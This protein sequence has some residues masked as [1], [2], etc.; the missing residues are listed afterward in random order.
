MAQYIPINPAV[1]SDLLK[2]YKTALQNDNLTIN[3]SNQTRSLDN[4]I[5]YTIDD[6]YKKVMIE[7]MVAPYNDIKKGEGVSLTGS[8]IRSGWEDNSGDINNNQV[9]SA[10]CDNY[11]MFSSFMANDKCIIYVATQNLELGYIINYKIN[12]DYTLTSSGSDALHT[13]HNTI[14]LDSIK[15]SNYRILCIF[16]S[17]GDNKIYYS[18]FEINETTLVMSRIK[19]G[20]FLDIVCGQDPTLAIEKITETFFIVCVRP[21]INI[22]NNKIFT[23]N[24]D[25]NFNITINNITDFEKPPGGY[26]YAYVRKIKKISDGNVLLHIIDEYTN[27]NYFYKIKLESDKSISF[28]K[29]TD[30][31]WAEVHPLTFCCE[32]SNN[33]FL[34]N[35]D[36]KYYVYYF[37]SNDNFIK[38]SELNVSTNYTFFTAFK[39]DRTSISYYSKSQS[40]IYQS[41]LTLN[42]DD[43]LS[44]SG[45]REIFNTNID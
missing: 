23:F 2:A 42:N 13:L 5:E 29:I 21:T 30:S 37:D 17:K 3:E 12:A 14:F 27:R 19:E 7:K 33:R 4:N 6:I 45:E 28:L 16:K 25:E 1:E 26:D 40:K 31:E 15:I 32:I 39:K 36:L 44:V 10:G 38:L 41:I 11:G 22:E 43:T 9:L 18:V 35:D 20:L 8:L 34:L 24:F